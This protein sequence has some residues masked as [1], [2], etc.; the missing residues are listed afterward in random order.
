MLSP[1]SCN[2]TCLSKTLFFK[3]Q[4][5]IYVTLKA[6]PIS[7]CELNIHSLPS[8]R[9]YLC[10]Y[11]CTY[12]ILPCIIIRVYVSV[13]CYSPHTS[14][15]QSIL[16]KVG[17]KQSYSPQR[18][19]GEALKKV[20]SAIFNVYLFHRTQHTISV[21]SRVT[22]IRKTNSYTINAIMKDKNELEYQ[23]V[24][25]RTMTKAFK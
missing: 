16:L 22:L 4:H 11:N 2:I 5:P 13:L 20:I 21:H 3:T 8:Q 10:F 9:D 1:L 23:S 18:Q 19:C 24:L 14:L 6:S 12:F 15:K 7:P 25:K 17:R